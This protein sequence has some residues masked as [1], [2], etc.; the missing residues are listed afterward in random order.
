MSAFIKTYPKGIGLKL[1]INF[2]TDEFDCKCKEC[3]ETMVSMEHV[4][5][6]QKLRDDFCRPVRI[7]SAYRCLTHNKI[8]GGV[9]GSQH[10]LGTA[11]DI[12]PHIAPIN[13]LTAHFRGV[14]LYPTFIH[15]DSRV[16][17]PIFID[18][19]NKK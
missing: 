9:D 14:I 18:K 1:S 8:V 17:S 12:A 6:L 16:S 3:I 15:L 13:Y 7:L 10:T 5:R 2:S 19:R 4:T 11:T